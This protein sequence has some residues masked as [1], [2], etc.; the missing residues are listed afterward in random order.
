FAVVVLD[1]NPNVREPFDGSPWRKFRGKSNSRCT[2]SHLENLC[3]I[4]G[5][6]SPN[7]VRQWDIPDGQGRPKCTSILA[8]KP[9]FQVFY[10]QL[11]FRVWIGIDCRKPTILAY[12]YP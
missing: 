9:Y 3:Q 6:K 4:L 1:R 11:S 10:N 12:E 2:F 8:C 7:G 5:T